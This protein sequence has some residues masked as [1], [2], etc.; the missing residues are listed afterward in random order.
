M[1][2]YIIKDGQFAAIARRLLRF[3]HLQRLAVRGRIR[4]ANFGRSPPPDRVEGQLPAMG[5]FDDRPWPGVEPPCTFPGNESVCPERF[6]GMTST[7]PPS[8]DRGRRADDGGFG[9]GGEFAVA[10]FH[11]AMRRW[12]DNPETMIESARTAADSIEHD[13]GRDF[14]S[15][16]MRIYPLLSPDSLAAALVDMSGQVVA[17]SPVFVAEKAE[18][19]IDPAVVGQVLRTGRTCVAPVAIE[20]GDGGLDP[21]IFAYGAAVQAAS[22]ILPSEIRARAE[23]AGGHV[24]V[25]ATITSLRATPLKAACETFGLTGLQ[26]RV[27]MATIRCGTIKQAAAQLDIAYDTARET[28]SEA[29]RRVGV[30]RLPA[31]VASLASLAFGVLPEGY[32]A[33][34]L[35]DIWGLSSRQAALASLIAEGLSR[36]AAA[37]RLG[38]SRATAKKE[39]DRIYDCLGVSSAA[40]LARAVIEAQA[41]SCTTAATQGQVAL[42]HDHAE[43]LRMMPRG[44]GTRIA[45]SDY[46]PASGKPV[47]VVHS[48]MTSRPVSRALVVALQ[49][50]GG[51]P[52]AIDRP[53]FGMSDPFHGMEPGAHDPFAIATR[54]VVS[55]CSKLRIPALDVVAR[56][57][58]QH[59]LALAD[60]APELIDRVVLV[61]PDPHTED[62]GRRWGPLGAVK[63]AYFRNPRLVAMM[64]RLISAHLTPERVA[65][66][67]ERSFAG[68]PPDLEAIRDPQVRSD[69]YRAVR[70]FATGRVAGYV[71]EQIAMAT[72]TRPAPRPQHCRWTVLIGEHDALHDPAD[73]RAYWQEVLPRAKFVEVMG[74]GRLLA[75]TEADLVARALTGIPPR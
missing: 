24:V 32:A 28:L 4:T 38:V 42:A 58:A 74:A 11:S 31:L 75:M 5:R 40:A 10:G 18:R 54:D 20:S 60:A 13:L 8:A 9:R 47:L 62:K 73:V 53:G 55:L 66:M 33:G 35:E 71:N 63:E 19:Y 72:A 22:W 12:L 37:Q 39:L 3:R 21:V 48:S 6:I 41:L 64:V 51:R 14:G 2:E 1:P 52:I 16:E 69:Y 70:M 7:L 46:G 65:R 15:E 61:N 49:A 29:M 25:L 68:S 17:A 34:L 23:L 57:G 56:G 43:P 26:T 27:A 30:D 67:M 36:D 50:A 59:V 45:W 44:D